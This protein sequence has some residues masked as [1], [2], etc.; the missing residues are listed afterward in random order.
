MPFSRPP[1]TSY[2]APRGKKTEHLFGFHFAVK[3]LTRRNAYAKLK[4]RKVTQLN[5]KRYG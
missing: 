5:K 3:E 4:T 2:E 1:N